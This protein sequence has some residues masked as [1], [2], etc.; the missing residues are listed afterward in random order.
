MTY[1]FGQPPEQ[2]ENEFLQKCLPDNFSSFKKS[3]FRM[4]SS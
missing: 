4:S 3:V 2:A 1:N